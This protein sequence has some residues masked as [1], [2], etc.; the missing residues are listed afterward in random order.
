[1]AVSDGDMLCRFIRKKDW[2]K[3]DQR[4]K[5]GAFKQALLS[6][7]HEGEL[8]AR[9]VPI[10]D[11]QIEHLAGTGQAY[12]TADD[13]K[14]FAEKASDLEG[15]QFAVQVEWRP[16]DEYVEEPWRPWSYAHVQV[17]AVEGPQAFLVEF[18]R[19]LAQNVRRQVNPL[20]Y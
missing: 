7:W 10:E 17:E 9:Q 4:P 16:G 18:R 15:V 3:R 6:V 1:M 5:P 13:Y 11:L 19:M 14:A 2:S 8:M 20:G 12:H